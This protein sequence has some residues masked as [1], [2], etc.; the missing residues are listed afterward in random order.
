MMI[1][2]VDPVLLKAHNGLRIQMNGPPPDI[3]RVQVINTTHSNFLL[4]TKLCT[5]LIDKSGR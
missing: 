3:A 1:Y 5:L 4:L 2:M